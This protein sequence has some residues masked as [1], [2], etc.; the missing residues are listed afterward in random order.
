M[1]E[2]EP[3]FCAFVTEARRIG[4]ATRARAE[5]CRSRFEVADRRRQPYPARMVT[6]EMRNSRELRDYLTAAVAAHKHMYLVD[7]DK[8]QLTE[9]AGNVVRAVHQHALERFGRYLENATRLAQRPRFVRCGYIAV[10]VIYGHTGQVKQL[11]H[12]AELVVYQALERR[13]IQAAE[14]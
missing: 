9:Q 8:A 5:P 11:V 2:S 7:N 10:P 4:A 1:L 3:P 6:D 14:R 12:S 13:D